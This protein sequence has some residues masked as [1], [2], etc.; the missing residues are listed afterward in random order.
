[1][2]LL[3]LP[4][5]NRGTKRKTSQK[6]KTLDPEFN[7]RSVNGPFHGEVGGF[8]CA[9]CS[10]PVPFQVR[11]GAAPRWVSQAKTRCVCEVKLLFHVKRA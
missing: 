5:K 6:K 3:L 10:N 11:V 8:S 9:L 7:E 2:S 4:D 1:M